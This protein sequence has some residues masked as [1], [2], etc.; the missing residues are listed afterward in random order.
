MINV[1]MKTT[2]I[3]DDWPLTLERFQTKVISLC[4]LTNSELRW[5]F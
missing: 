5:N 4:L 2:C 1:T 3:N